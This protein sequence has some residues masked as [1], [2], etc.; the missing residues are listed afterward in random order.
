MSRFAPVDNSSTSEFRYFL[1][2]SLFLSLSPQ[3]YASIA[4]PSENREKER[5][6]EERRGKPDREKKRKGRARI[7][8]SEKKKID[9]DR[10]NRESGKVRY[11][12]RTSRVNGRLLVVVHFVEEGLA[13]EARL[14]VWVMYWH[15][16][17][18][19]AICRESERLEETRAADGERQS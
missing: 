13:G 17:V 6:G 18:I 8:Q 16:Y 12:T 14:A 15:M 2:L 5:R 7:E 3:L 1:F 11:R 19:V 10:G 4:A 9:D